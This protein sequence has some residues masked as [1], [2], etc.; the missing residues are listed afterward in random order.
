M[1]KCCSSTQNKHNTNINQNKNSNEKDITNKDNKENV[2]NKNTDKPDTVKASIKQALSIKLRFYYDGK[3][4]GMEPLDVLEDQSLNDVLEP[5][6]HNLPELSDYSYRDNDNLPVNLKSKL[7]EIFK[8]KDGKYIDAI[9]T[10]NVVY[11]GLDIPETKEKILSKYAQTTL[12]ANPVLLSN[13]YPLELRVYDSETCEFNTALLNIEENPELSTFSHYSAF[14]NGNNYVYLSGGDVEYVDETTGEKQTKYLDWISKINLCDGKV[15]KL[16]P[17]KVPRYWHSM[18][19][20]PNKYVFIV[21]GNRTTSVEVLNTETGEITE[22]SHLNEMHSEPSLC[23]VNSNFL[24]CFLGYQMDEKSEYSNTIER[25]NLRREIRTWEIVSVALPTGE[26]TTI[27]SFIKK[28][29]FVT[30]Y[31]N[32]SSILILGGRDVVGDKTDRAKEGIY[33]VYD[34][35]NDSVKEVIDENDKEDRNQEIANTN[36]DADSQGKTVGSFSKLNEEEFLEKFF[37]PMKTNTNEIV[38]VSIPVQ[39]RD[40]RRVY[41]INSQSHVEIKEYEDNLNNTTEQNIEY[42]EN[43][44]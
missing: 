31:Y 20:V 34:Y 27:N 36:E 11:Q 13:S 29:F 16:E 44:N 2:N 19:Y 25:C 3:P 8:K 22:D 9:Q 4:I 5:V 30:S 32:N 12:Y 41:L 40:K 23:L 39:T 1:G 42:E 15:T 28:R 35:K 24:Y 38:S 33:Y 17:M 14:C 18:I 10:I 43:E 6:E 26:R 7:S 37:V 21:G